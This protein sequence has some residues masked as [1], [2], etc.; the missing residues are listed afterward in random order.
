MISKPV[1]ACKFLQMDCFVN[2]TSNTFLLS[3]FKQDSSAQQ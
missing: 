1:A 3:F 2:L